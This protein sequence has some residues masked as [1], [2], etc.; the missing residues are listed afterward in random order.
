MEY[1]CY[2]KQ[3]AFALGYLFESNFFIKRKTDVI[4]VWLDLVRILITVP[5]SY[6]RQDKEI[7]IF[8]NENFKRVFFLR[9]NQIVSLN[10]PFKLVPTDNNLLEIYI[11]DQKMTGVELSKLQEIL[12]SE[13]FFSSCFYSDIDRIFNT[14]EEDKIWLLLKEVLLAEDGYIRYDYDIEH[15]PDVPNHFDI[16][17]TNNSTFKLGLRSAINLDLMIDIL[18]KN[19][20]IYFVNR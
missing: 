9:D 17:F 19:T 12:N 13:E 7:I 4:K 5:Y 15:H 6:N 2:S 1:F 3:E 10:F 8:K 11:R 14:E 16:F 18:D 20:N